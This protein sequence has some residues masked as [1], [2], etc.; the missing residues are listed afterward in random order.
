MMLLSKQLLLSLNFQSPRPFSRRSPRNLSRVGTMLLFALVLAILSPNLASAQRRTIA[1]PEKQ[2]LTTKDGVKLNAT[3]YAS[4]S[5]KDATPVVLLHDYKESSAIYRSLARRLQ[6]PAEGDRHKS[7]AVL[8]VD[9]RG[10]GDSKQQAYKGRT[11]E[12]DAAKLSKRDLEAIVLGDMEAVRKFLVSENDK[13]KLNLNKLAV[14]GTG[15]GAVVGTNWAARDWS[16]PP[17]ATVKQGQDVKS[18][19]L[20]SPPWKTKGLSMQDAV[21]QPGVQREIAILMLFG[22]EDRRATKDVDRIYGQLEQYHPA[23]KTAE[24]KDL[25]DLLKIGAGTKL[26]GSQLLKTGGKKLE[27]VVIEFLTKH[28]AKGDFEYSKRRQL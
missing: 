14:I 25:P 27:D 15:M 18:L 10:H 16:M 23:A 7:F 21:R 17:L 11:R 12:L 26:Q 4:A 13:G 28:V 19:V 20:I 22:N 5:G 1:E 8:T 9:F 6:K 24:P 3:Y 2:E